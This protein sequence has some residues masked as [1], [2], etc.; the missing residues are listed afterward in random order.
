MKYC[1]INCT[2]ACKDDALKVAEELV[3][4][5]LIACCNIIPGVVSVYNW[6]NKLNT[7]DEVLTVMKTRLDLYKRVKTEIK[8]LHKYETPEIIAIPIEKVNDDYA[9]WI[10]EQ[11]DY[12]TDK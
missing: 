8:K 3:N 10:D 6:K 4:K 5:K 2:F 1:T 11:T 7:D 12:G 9:K